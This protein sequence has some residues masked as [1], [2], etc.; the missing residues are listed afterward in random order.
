[1]CQAVVH[2]AFNS[3]Y[4]C[5]SVV[6]SHRLRSYLTLFR[7]TS[8]C[9]LLCSSLLVD[10]VTFPFLRALVRSPAMPRESI[11]TFLAT[12]FADYDVSERIPRFN[13]LGDS[14]FIV[15]HSFCE[16]NSIA[17]GDVGPSNDELLNR[18]K[19]EAALGHQIKAIGSSMRK[20]PSSTAAMAFAR[21]W[22]LR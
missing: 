8:L 6:A 9:I 22:S 20:F 2:L 1:M 14:V 21:T 7:A 15:F 13:D 18:G 5:R 11:E 3:T 16:Q 17:G 10:V 4:V 12:T 19:T